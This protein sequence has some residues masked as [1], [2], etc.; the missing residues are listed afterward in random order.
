[1]Q[2]RAVLRFAG[3]V[4]ILFN[5]LVIGVPVMLLIGLKDLG[6]IPADQIPLIILCVGTLCVLP[7]IYVITLLRIGLIKDFNITDRRQRV[8]LFPVVLICLAA[9]VVILSRNEGTSQLVLKMPGFGLVSCVVCALITVWFK[10][11]LHC[12]GLGW[13]TVGLY[14]AFG[15]EALCLGLGGLCL[16]AWSRLVLREHTL[17]EVLAGSVFGVGVTWMEFAWF[18]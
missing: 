2:D 3:K 10:I 4:S 11:S 15:I 14:Q 5:P 17:T 7:L 16:A 6:G 9:V 8:Y 12:V 13:M 1:M 18:V